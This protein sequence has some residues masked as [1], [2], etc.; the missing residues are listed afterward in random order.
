KC[1]NF[2]IDGRN[3]SAVGKYLTLK[4]IIAFLGIV[5]SFAFTFTIRG[6]YKSTTAEPQTKFTLNP[7]NY[8]GEGSREAKAMAYIK[9]PEDLDFAGEKVP[10]HLQPV[11]QKYSEEASG[12]AYWMMPSILLEQ[13]RNNLYYE[14]RSILK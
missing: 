10:W 2:G 7:L 1:R 11:R 5:C 8:S 3:Y 14:C 13:E 4:T 9:V 12:E 6:Y